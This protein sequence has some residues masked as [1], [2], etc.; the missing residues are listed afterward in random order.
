MTLRIV[1]VNCVIDESRRAPADLFAAWPTLSATADAAAHA[2]AD[3]TV[4]QASRVPGEYRDR[5][6]TYRFVAEPRWQRGNGAG[7]MP[8]RIGAAIRR[9]RPD[10]VHFN[11]L[12]FPFHV[13][14]ACSAGAPVLVQDHAS[15]AEGRSA[16][17]R[18][19]G[20]EKIAGVA[21]T[22]RAQAEPFL[23]RHQLPRS[24]QLF[25]VPESSSHFTPGDRDAARRACGIYGA[26]A[27]LWIGHLDANKNPL[28]MLHGVR[29][30]LATLP[31]LHVWCAFA[32]IGLLGE[33]EALLRADPRLAGHVHLLGT[34]PHPAIETLCRAADL[35]VSTSRREGSGYALIE[36]LA[37]GMTPVIS[38]IPSFRALTGH[39]AL[40]A[41]VPVGDAD[42]LAAAIIDQAQRPREAARAAVRA[43]FEQ[44]LAFDAIGA[45]LMAAYRAIATPTTRP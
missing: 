36:A 34:V 29:T 21:F 14:A 44:H 27:L 22:A 42:A 2:G 8:W 25:E 18:A 28:T 12:D 6:V 43:H 9:V 7:S 31:D 26:P 23:R 3:V 35:F 37:C 24:A 13:R 38:D 15:R 11:G 17:L 19:W 32:G 5:G 10:V 30:A 45:Q 39:G 1:Q 20:H 33:I 41:L 4:L 40:G 16:R